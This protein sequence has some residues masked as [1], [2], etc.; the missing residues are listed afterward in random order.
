MGRS[1]VTVTFVLGLLIAA[2]V[3][4]GTREFQLVEHTSLLVRP[5]VPPLPPRQH[6]HMARTVASATP[7]AESPEEDAI[8][9]LEPDLILLATTVSNSLPERSRAH[10]HDRTSHTRYVLAMEQHI[11]GYDKLRLV[12]IED[13]RVVFD[14]NGQ[15]LDL[16]LDEDTSWPED[17]EMRPAPVKVTELLSMMKVRQDGESE[18]A[19]A[20]RFEHGLGKLYRMDLGLRTNEAL[21]KHGVFA[22]KKRDGRQVGFYASR[23]NKGSFWDTM[24]LESGDVVLE[25]NGIPIEGPESNR[26]AV[27]EVVRSETHIQ[28]LVERKGELFETSTRTLPVASGI[29]SDESIEY[30]EG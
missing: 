5:E 6:Q 3:W 18:E 10:V 7:S 20:A 19:F 9:T 16:V 26:S 2:L 28:L 12:E 29:W 23:I 4:F 8:T 11:Q 21:F 22:P 1:I 24:G 15:S 30:D 17:P 13:G 27:Q 25:V 14:Y